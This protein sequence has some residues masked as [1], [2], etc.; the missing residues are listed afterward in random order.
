M[1]A[2]MRAGAPMIARYDGYEKLNGY[3]IE[4]LA[5]RASPADSVL[6]RR[7]ELFTAHCASLER[8]IVD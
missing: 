2:E 4:G 8:W 5:I 7:N 6:F 3:V 1:N